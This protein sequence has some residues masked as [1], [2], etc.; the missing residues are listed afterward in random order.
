M[1]RK[2]LRNLYPVNLRTAVGAAA[3]AIFLNAGSAHAED[4]W[5]F[6]FTPY[7][8]ATNVGVNA[9]LDGQEVLD[10]QISVSDLLDDLETIFQGRF[11]VQR[12]SLGLTVDLFDVNLADSKNGAALPENSGTADLTTDAGMTLLDVA[13]V[14]DPKGNRE[15]F[16]FL[17]GARLL[18]ERATVVA[19]LNPAGG[20]SV[21]KTYET[22][23]WLIDGLIGARFEHHFTRHWGVQSQVDVSTGST[24]YTWSVTSL[25]SYSFGDRGRFGI[26]VGYR[27]MDVNFEEHGGL[28][29]K[30]TLS[31]PMFGFRMS[32]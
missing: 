14:Y 28:Q 21:P 4:P 6:N 23:D 25:V 26:D 1:N 9:K 11:T 19:T 18:N 12:G 5:T 22:S 3:L 13:G 24:R 30:M 29:T 31:G 10:K 17:A 15:G 32:F 8:W 2:S 20:T 16:S 27:R 7:M